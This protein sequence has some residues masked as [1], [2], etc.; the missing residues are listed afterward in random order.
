MS[1]VSVKGYAAKR[2][3]FN[4]LIDVSGSMRVYCKDITHFLNEFIKEL[5]EQREYKEAK[6]SVL[7][8]NTEVTELLPYTALSEI[9]ILDEISELQGGTDIGKA[10]LKGIE[11]SQREMERA[12]QEAKSYEAPF[13][14]LITDGVSNAGWGAKQMQQEAVAQN[15]DKACAKAKRLHGDEDWLFLVMRLEN[16]SD[17]DCDEKKELEE[18]KRITT[19]VVNYEKGQPMDSQVKRVFDIFKNVIVTKTESAQRV[20][21]TATPIS[22]VMFD[23]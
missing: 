14:L 9:D 11:C 21:P 15:F 3:F 8:F 2:I 19:H 18:L 7:K 22:D 20:N 16:A 13:V 5:R 10:L 17:P 23:Y 12:Q 6:I 1:F 4:V